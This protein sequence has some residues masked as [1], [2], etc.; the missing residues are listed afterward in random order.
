M[1]KVNA[2]NQV[3]KRLWYRCNRCFVEDPHRPGRLVPYLFENP[4]FASKLVGAKMAVV[5]KCPRCGA[6]AGAASCVQDAV[7]WEPW[8]L[9]KYFG[10]TRR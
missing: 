1:V 3:E 7:Y 8:D 2:D 6:E 9:R 4:V 10:K 5:K